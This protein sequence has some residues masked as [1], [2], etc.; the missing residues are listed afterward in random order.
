M[1]STLL[2]PSDTHWKVMLEAIV[3]EFV[4]C[5]QPT[6]LPRML[7]RVI[8]ADDPLKREATEITLDDETT[9]SQL[10]ER[11]SSGLEGRP[12]PDSMRIIVQGRALGLA[13]G[14]EKLRDVLAEI[15]QVRLWK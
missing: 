10:R 14:G 3:F 13:R 4:L 7:V 9:V 2:R 1:V 5:I 15:D 11:L 6:P 12:A 8:V